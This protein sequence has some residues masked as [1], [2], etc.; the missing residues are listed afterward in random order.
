MTVE[1]VDEVYKRVANK[2]E[3]LE[4]SKILPRLIQK[5]LT[6]VQAEL[7]SE[8]PGTPEELAVRVKRDLNSV[9]KDLQYMYELGMG[10]PSARS[11]KWNLPRNYVLLLDKVGSHHAKFLPF[12]GPEYLDLWDEFIEEMIHTTAQ[13]IK[14]LPGEYASSHRFPTYNCHDCSF[15]IDFNYYLMKVKP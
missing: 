11:G 1:E 13:S 12:L 3:G 7:A 10:T 2:I 5:M 15:L 8:F 14:S 4:V 9:K 6:P